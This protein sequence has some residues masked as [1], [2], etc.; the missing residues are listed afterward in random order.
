MTTSSA[1]S[2]RANSILSSLPTVAMT[3]APTRRAIWIAALPTPLPAAWTNTVWPG[4]SPARAMSACHEVSIAIG[5]AAP[6][7]NEIASGSDRMF[8]AGAFTSSA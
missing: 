1:P 6:V 5:S 4:E 3:R 7:S 2:A 8:A